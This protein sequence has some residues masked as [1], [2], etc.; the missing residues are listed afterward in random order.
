MA[1]KSYSRA[2]SLAASGSSRLDQRMATAYRQRWCAL[3][4]TGG[5]PP[6]PGRK[7]AVVEAIRSGALGGQSHALPPRFRNPRALSVNFRESLA[8]KYHAHAQWRLRA[9]VLVQIKQVRQV[10]PGAHP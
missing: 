3:L 5:L 2:A 6:V 4:L 7:R 1:R 8:T 10:S 9:S